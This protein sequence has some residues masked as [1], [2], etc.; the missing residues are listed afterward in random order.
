M[1]KVYVPDTLVS[2]VGD[3]CGGISLAAG[4][5][6]CCESD[7][8][9]LY[10]KAPNAEWAT[11][12]SAL[13]SEVCE[14]AKP[15]IEAVY[16]GIAYTLIEFDVGRWKWAFYPKD[17]PSQQGELSAIREHAEMACMSAINSWFRTK[18]G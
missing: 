16:K 10:V 17:G 13:F 7:N 14:A 3:W 1:L 15:K 18:S 2:Q 4:V 9:G 11:R 5:P 6:I 12:L 8:S